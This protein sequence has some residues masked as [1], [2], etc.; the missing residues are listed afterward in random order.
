[1]SVYSLFVCLF[2][3]SRYNKCARE[4][5]NYDDKLFEEKSRV[6]GV[7]CSVCK[8]KILLQLY[9]SRICVVLSWQ[10]LTNF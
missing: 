4:G 5:R 1:V 9:S 6:Y 2:D 10:S 7:R 8:L 3:A